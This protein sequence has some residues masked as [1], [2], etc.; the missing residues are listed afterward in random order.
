VGIK[1]GKTYPDE[2]IMLMAHWDH[3]G[4]DSSLDGDQIYNGAVDNAT[5]TALIMSVAERLKNEDTERSV[6][7]LGLT[8]EE[9]GLLG[10]AY[11]AENFPFDYSQIVAGMNFDGIPAIGKTKD[12]LVIGYGASELEDVLKK[13]LKKIFK[14]HYA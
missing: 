11:L 2:F 6:M 7:F 1:K 14:G 4:K 9:S 12:M 8:A 10:S 5:G 3:L 13:H